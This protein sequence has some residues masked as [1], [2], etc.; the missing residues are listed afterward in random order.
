MGS[1]DSSRWVVRVG[2]LF[3]SDVSMTSDESGRVVPLEEY[4]GASVDLSASRAYVFNDKNDA[5]SASLMV[6]GTVVEVLSNSC[7]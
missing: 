5:F 7:M 1:E 2:D 6:H 3:V 4:P